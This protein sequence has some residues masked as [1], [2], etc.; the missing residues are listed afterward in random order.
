MQMAPMASSDANCCSGQIDRKGQ[1]GD[2]GDRG[3]ESGR[4]SGHTNI[5]QCLE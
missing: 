5:Y 2:R 4:K 1:L 3:G